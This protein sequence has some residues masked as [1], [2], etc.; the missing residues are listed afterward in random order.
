M[1]RWQISIAV[2]TAIAV[3]APRAARAD[4]PWAVGVSA[5]HK[6]Q[7]QTL[8]E[9]GNAQFLER[10][11][12]EALATYQQA[13]AIWDH[14]AIRFNV[15]R[16]LIQLG[17]PVEAYDNLEIALRYGEAPLESSVYEE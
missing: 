15:V 7:A 14:P 8:L 2:V 3:A 10:K 13:L 11:Y 5:E 17:R 4:Q 16:C 9:A 1:R 12:P 6:A